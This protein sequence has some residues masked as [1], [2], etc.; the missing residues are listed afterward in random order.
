MSA[1]GLPGLRGTFTGSGPGSSNGA[2]TVR[3][4][5]QLALPALFV[6]GCSENARNGAATVRERLYLGTLPLFDIRGSVLG[7]RA[8]TRFSSLGVSGPL[9]MEKSAPGDRHTIFIVG[10][11]WSAGHGERC[12]IQRRRAQSERQPGGV[13]RHRHLAARSENERHV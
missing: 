4:R 2:A 5:W 8:R 9:V 10:S 6:R 1:I 3:E 11:E 13:C 12:E 7:E